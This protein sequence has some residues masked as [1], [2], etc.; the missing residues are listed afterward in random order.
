MAAEREGERALEPARLAAVLAQALV[1]AQQRDARLLVQLALLVGVGE[2]AATPARLEQRQD[3]LG[4]AVGGAV[5]ALEHLVDEDPEALVERRLA[6][7]PQDARELVAQRAG[8]VGLDVGGREHEAVAAARQEGLERR[9]L[10]RGEGAGAHARVGAG[11]EQRV[12]DRRALQ[13]LALQ[14]RDRGGQGAR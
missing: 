7:D 13:D 1:V 12:V 5:E 14:R 8:A 3:L 6:R 11:G 2:A 4:A 10:A 9:L